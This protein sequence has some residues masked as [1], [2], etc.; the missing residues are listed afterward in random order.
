VEVMPHRITGR[1]VSDAYP[2]AG[3]WRISTGHTSIQARNSDGVF[4]ICGMVPGEYTLR[5]NTRR[6]D[7]TVAGELKIRIEDEDLGGLEIVPEES[8]TIRA[9]IES[10]DHV[11]L[12]L[13]NG[14][15]FGFPGP[16]AHDSVPQSRRQPDGSFL[17]DEVYTGEYR[18]VSSLPPGS[19]LKSARINGQDVMDAPLL[20]HGGE[21]L[22]GLVFTVSSKAARLTGVVQD[23]T[24]KPVPNAQIMMLPDPKHLDLDIHTCIQQ[25]DQNGGF[26][27]Y[28]VAPG[29]YRI[30]A[31]P[32]YPPDGLQARN[33]VSLKGTPVEVS[34]SER[35]SITLTVPKL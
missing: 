15:I 34:E 28:S 10:E 24:G 35:A 13:A 6:D 19:Y 26:T 14:S 33:E 20:V 27:C 25:T 2:L 7:R 16:F 31:W 23:E 9:R 21:N 18:F 12:D 4:A 1:I 29:K 3:L 8:A 30:A 17:I 32:T 22:D 5:V 11:P